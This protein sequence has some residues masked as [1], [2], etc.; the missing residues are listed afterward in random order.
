MRQSPIA[1]CQSDLIKLRS[2]WLDREIELQR[3]TI[4]RNRLRGTLQLRHPT[5]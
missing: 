4:E 2:S 3:Q 5:A 1:R